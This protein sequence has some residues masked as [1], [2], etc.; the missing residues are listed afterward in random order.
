MN[1][2]MEFKVSSRFFCH[3]VNPVNPVYRSFSMFGQ[4]LQ[5]EQDYGV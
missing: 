4:D 1:K 2:I 5:D 3:L